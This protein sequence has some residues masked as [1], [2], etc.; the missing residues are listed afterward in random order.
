MHRRA[1]LMLDEVQNGAGISFLPGLFCL[2]SATSAGISSEWL[3]SWVWT[4][5]PPARERSVLE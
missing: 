5:L 3:N 2:W 4:P 1:N